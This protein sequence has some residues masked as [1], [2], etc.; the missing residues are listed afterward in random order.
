[1]IRRAIL[2]SVLIMLLVPLNLAA[3]DDGGTESVF[4]LGAGARAM[5]MGN[6]YTALV[7]DAT[8][9][10]YNP[11]AMPFLPSQQISFLHTVLFESTVYDFASYVYPLS[12]F[13]GFGIAAMRLGTDDIGR[14]DENTD[15]GRFNASRMQLLLSYGRR[16]GQ[17]YSAGASL[18]LA[19]QSID[20]YSAYGYGLDLAGRAEITDKLRAG[21]LLQDIIGSRMK[22]ATVKER[23]PFTFR[24][25][26]AY[27]VDLKNSPFSGTA[28]FDLEKPENRSAKLRTGV[29]I[30]HTSGLALRGG[31]DRDNVTLGMGLVYQQLNFDYAFKFMKHLSDS[32]RFSLSFS[33]G[34]TQ[35]DRQASR[36]EE[37]QRNRDN[38]LQA[39]RADAL[40]RDLKKADAWFNSGKLDSALSA[41][42][43]ASTHADDPGTEKHINT[44]ITGILHMQEEARPSQ[45]DGEA[46]AMLVIH[47]ATDM[48]EKGELKAARDIIDAAIGNKID[49]TELYLLRREIVFRMDANIKT[50]L[51]EAEKSFDHGDYIE[52]YNKY[53]S[54]LTLD[55]NNPHARDGSRAAKI[56]MDIAQLMKM[57]MDYYDQDRYILSQ[58]EFNAVLLLDPGNE[59]ARRHL[60]NI[61]DKLRDSGTQTEKDLRHDQELWQIYLDGVEAYRAGDFKKAIELWDKVLRKYPN[62]KM[63]LENKKQAELRVKE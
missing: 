56:Q 4:N 60:R 22:L 40:R 33:F 21:V 63:T 36:I 49:A 20:D 59:T 58:R 57:A 37:E 46:R 42:Y 6:G 50:F 35:D 55:V 48:M 44:R 17:R 61:D 54:V 39:Q 51:D 24:A 3:S 47:Q 23:T 7:E 10:Y 30:A 2:I 31:Y 13:G 38:Y 18:K 45:A 62:D 26:L 28:T 41:Y 52:A 27:L 5:G 8:A 53:N 14:R 32:H 19:H 34:E 9:V 43:R 12:D 11:A 15:L 1:M 29:E 25:G 16:I